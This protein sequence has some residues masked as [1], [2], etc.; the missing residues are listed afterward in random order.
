MSSVDIAAQFAAQVAATLGQPTQRQ[1]QP[2]DV[3]A[4]ATSAT[5]GPATE[6]VASQ[7]TTTVESTEVPAAVVH[8]QKPVETPVADV[9]Q[10]GAPE[11]AAPDQADSK[12]ATQ[13][14]PETQESTP[15]VVAKKTPSPDR[16][17]PTTKR[18]AEKKKVTKIAVASVTLAPVSVAK[19]DTAK[20]SAV[21]ATDVVVHKNTEETSTTITHKPEPKTRT[22]SLENETK[23]VSSGQVETPVSVP[24]KAKTEVSRETKAPDV[25]A[26]EESRA[27]SATVTPVV[28]DE[29]DPKMKDVE[30]RCTCSYCL[31]EELCYVDPNNCLALRIGGPDGGSV[32]EMFCEEI[33]SNCT[34]HDSSMQFVFTPIYIELTRSLLTSAHDREK[35]SCCCNVHLIYQVLQQFIP[36]FLYIFRL[37]S[38]FLLLFLSMW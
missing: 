32:V 16:D 14:T 37:F 17:E 15:V 6:P 7:E 19:P 8:E 28:V 23:P 9:S 25:T 22:K 30:G 3:P 26:V 24:S 33:N 36:I 13:S 38:D 18:V 10:S 35:R 5:D 12:L 11:P 2:Q 31:V 27:K 4:Q 21:D 20:D 1:V 29:V 34:I